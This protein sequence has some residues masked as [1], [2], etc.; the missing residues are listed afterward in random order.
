MYILYA[1][2]SG[3]SGSKSYS[4]ALWATLLSY[5]IILY[6]AH[7]VPQI[8]RA[9]LQR[10]LMDENTQYLLLA[11]IWI[12]S[13]PVWV[14]LIPYATFSFFHSINYI[15]AAI[16]PTLFPPGSPLHSTITT[17]LSPLIESFSQKYQVSALRSI[18]YLEVWFLFPYLVLSIFV[19]HVSFLTPI[20]YAQFLRFRF[21]FSPMTK[22]AFGELKGRLDGLV[23]RNGT[24]EWVVAFYRKAVEMVTRWGDVG[25]EMQPQRPG[26]ESRRDR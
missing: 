19:G 24:P 15:R 6:K 20:L 12:T 1:R 3:P 4:K 25:A 11:L 22:E 21:Y 17:R 2:F 14:V 9:Y 7:G 5:G 18:S 10:I 23:L 13:K 8:K 16:L 26:E